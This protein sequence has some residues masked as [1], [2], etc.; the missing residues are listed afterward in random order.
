MEQKN[1]PA[2]MKKRWKILIGFI[3]LLIFASFLPD[4]NK[5]STADNISV[6]KNADNTSTL[7]IVLDEEAYAK[8]N[9]KIV[10]VEEFD[11]YNGSKNRIIGQRLLITLN[12]NITEDDIIYVYENHAKNTKYNWISVIQPDGYGC[13]L[14]GG[15]DYFTCS[16]LDIEE[17]G[18]QTGPT[19]IV[20]TINDNGTIRY[21][22]NSKKL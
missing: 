10:N 1:K 18:M 20:A 12:D 21:P 15:A 4:E 13:L 5:P 17:E 19:D 2:K 6:V 14:H 11:V 8:R 9:K 3:V 22:E 7:T 16:K